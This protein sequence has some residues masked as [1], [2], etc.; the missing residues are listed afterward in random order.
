MLELPVVLLEAGKGLGLLGR[1]LRRVFLEADKRVVQ[2]LHLLGMRLC[3]AL[4]RFSE[5]AVL[6][7][8][9]GKLLLQLLI[10]GGVLLREFLAGLR[11]LLLVFLGLTRGKRLHRLTAVLFLRRDLRGVGLR[12]LGLFLRLRDLTDYLRAAMDEAGELIERAKRRK[13]FIE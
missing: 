12:F 8:R 4:Y 6:L 7:V 3:L 1:L 2:G 11:G 13:G 5:F 9:F 10:V